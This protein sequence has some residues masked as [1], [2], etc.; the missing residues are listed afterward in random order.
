MNG[1]KKTVLS[2]RFLQGQFPEQLL[3]LHWLP[4]LQLSQVQFT[5]SHLAC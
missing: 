4:Q 2:E 1:N 3:Q 5:L